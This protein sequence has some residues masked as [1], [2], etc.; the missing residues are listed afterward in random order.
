M[1]IAPYA[2]QYLQA[3]AESSRSPIRRGLLEQLVQD[4]MDGS[5]AVYGHDSRQ[6]SESLIEINRSIYAYYCC[7]YELKHLMT[8]S[9][10]GLF[11]GT[12]SW[13]DWALIAATIDAGCEEEAERCHVHPNSVFLPAPARATLLVTAYKGEYEPLFIYPNGYTPLQGLVLL[14]RAVTEGRAATESVL[15]TRQEAKH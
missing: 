7:R 13:T 6:I 8:V 9:A 14:S 3:M 15:I 4:V 5:V 12:I 1:I 11:P 10:Y 2:L